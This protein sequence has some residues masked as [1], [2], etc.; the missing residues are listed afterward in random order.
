MSLLVRKIAKSKWPKGDFEGVDIQD[1]RADA[2]TSCLRTSDD[3]LS[4]WEIPSLNDLSDAVLALV[5]SFERIDKIDVVIIDKEEVTKRGFEIVDTPGNTPV[6]QLQQT[7]RDIT[8][9]T[10]GTV[11]DFSRLL[12]DTMGTK[13]RV[14]RY[15]AKKVKNLL[16]D[17]IKNGILDLH[18]LKEGV[19]RNLAV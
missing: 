8:G 3:T 1:L 18:S 11:G 4:T 6:E 17:A 13:G 7:H 9:L 12:L 16:N 5:S 2:I 14:E 15:T 19:Q 10:Y